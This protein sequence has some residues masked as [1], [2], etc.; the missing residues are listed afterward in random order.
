VAAGVLAL[1]L[2]AGPSVGFALTNDGG[3]TPPVG[4]D[5][6]TTAPAE[7]PSASP[8]TSP[9]PSASPPAAPDGRI[10]LAD[11]EK[12]SLDLP[13]WRRDFAGDC[14]TFDMEFEGQPVYADVDHDGAEE[15]AAVLWCHG[16]GEFRVYKVM[17]FDRDPAG[18]IV[19]LG[20]VLEAPGEGD[21]GVAIWK[22][23]GVQAA[24]GGQ[25]RVD[26]G[27]YAPCCGT[28][29]DLAQHQWRTY[30]WDG[31]RFTQTGGPTKFGPN[32]KITDLRVDSGDLVM[33]RQADGTWRGK[34]TFTVRNAGPFPAH[35]VDVNVSGGRLRATGDG[36]TGWTGTFD[37]SGDFYAR[38]RLGDLAPGASRTIALDLTSTTGP[39]GT[40][41]IGV[42]HTMAGDTGER[43]YPDKNQDDNTTEVPIRAA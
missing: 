11:I 22:V 33:T 32:P 25:I 4:G 3:G 20:Q 23:W 1:A 5:P 42:G 14:A 43:G 38:W 40:L 24:P 6:S 21:E 18:K 12:A 8:S 34:V 10:S 36:W 13:P 30:G 7:S 15:T 29:P 41:T 35:V 31:K 26:V 9:S 28:A 37:G 19:T 16:G 2:L 17:V 39:A 27:D